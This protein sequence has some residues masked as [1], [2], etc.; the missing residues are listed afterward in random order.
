M[1][2]IIL[3]L[4]KKPVFSKSSCTA[5]PEIYLF[6]D[7]FGFCP[8]FLIANLYEN[9]LHLNKE[10]ENNAFRIIRNL[11]E[12]MATQEHAGVYSTP[13]GQPTVYQQDIT[14]VV[15]PIDRIRWGSVIAGL[16]ATLCSLLVLNVLGVAIGLST[17]QVDNG[18]GAFGMGAGIWGAISVLIS[19]AIG[20]WLAARSAAVAGRDNGLLNGAMVWVVA[21]PLMLYLIAAGA[22]SVLNTAATASAPLINSAANDPAVQNQGENAAGNAQDAIGNVTPEQAEQA[23]RNASGAAWGTLLSLVLSF[24]AAAIGGAVGAREPVMKQVTVEQRT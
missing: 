1:L 14:A 10:M 22:T 16:L 2:L 24:A 18:L 5:Y 3:S 6:M 12:I 9:N 15:R 8:M 13:A 17:V 20:G 23:A 4:L 21:I 19:F 7:E 11:G